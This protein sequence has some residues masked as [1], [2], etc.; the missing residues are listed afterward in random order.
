VSDAG[1]F[2]PW[3]LDALIVLVV[4]EAVALVAYHRATGGGVA[5]REFALH[6][7][8]GLAL[9]LAWRSAASHGLGTAALGWLFAAGVLHAL[10]LGRRWRRRRLTSR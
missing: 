5:P 3:L 10:E 8:S 9:L 4:I 1:A 6:L 2:P 7:L